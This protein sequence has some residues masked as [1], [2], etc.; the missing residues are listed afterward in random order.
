MLFIRNN[1]NGLKEI[2]VKYLCII[3]CIIYKSTY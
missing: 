1:P 2:V 3:I